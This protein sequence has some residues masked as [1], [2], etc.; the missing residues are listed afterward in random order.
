MAAIKFDMS[1]IE[2]N[3]RFHFRSIIHGWHRHRRLGM[4]WHS[5]LHIPS[6]L[7]K[8][9]SR[10]INTQQLARFKWPTHIQS[11][12]CTSTASETVR[13]QLPATF[14]D[15][16]IVAISFESFCFFFVFLLPFPIVFQF[17]FFHRK[18]LFISIGAVCVDETANAVHAFLYGWLVS[19]TFWLKSEMG[20]QFFF[21]VWGKWRIQD[22]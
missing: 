3:L 8:Q 14:I 4:F 1:R 17:V 2:L 12:I 18:W 5:L 20:F 7:N 19:L 11:A 21:A 16:I 10:L 13:D 9:C 22:E 6:R 15:A